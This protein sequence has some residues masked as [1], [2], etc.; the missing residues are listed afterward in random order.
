MHCSIGVFLF[1]N[2]L[3]LSTNKPAILASVQVTVE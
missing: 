3:L 1:I 2:C